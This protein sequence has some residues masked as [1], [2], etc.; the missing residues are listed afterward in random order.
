M[1]RCEHDLSVALLCTR[2][3]PAS[4]GAFEQTVEKIVEYSKSSNPEICFLVA[5]D[6]SLQMK[7]I[8]H[9]NVK[10]LFLKRSNGIGVIIYGLKSIILAYL[11]GV[12]TM[13]F[14]GYALA[15]IFPLLKMIGTNVI[16]NTDGFEWRR[17]KWGRV[18]RFYFKCCEFIC[19]RSNIQLVSDARTIQRYYSI[20]YRAKSTLIRYGADTYLRETSDTE[21]YFVVVMRMEPENNILTIVKAFS[22]SNQTAKLYLIGP[23]TKYFEDEILEII[24]GDPRIHFLG[25][26]Y[27]RQRLFQIRSKAMA[28]IHGHSVGGTNPTLVE[29]CFIG[30]PVISYFSSFNNEVLKGECRYFSDLD[31]LKSIFDEGIDLKLPTPPRLGEEYEWRKIVDN[32]V[33][34]LQNV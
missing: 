10:R 1:S 13:V 2:G 19:G 3:L 17:A 25:P 20:K 4:Y 18:A 16:C 8:E 29:A 11:M 22:A 23:S 34:L 33:G 30:K 27:D 15:P 31:T 24:K 14:F 9:T 21:R 7:E 28:Y 32:Y 26:I 12:R 5:T 6:K